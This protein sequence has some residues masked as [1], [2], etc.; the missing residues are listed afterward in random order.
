LKLEKTKGT[1]EYL[2]IDSASRPAGL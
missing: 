1:R 2:A